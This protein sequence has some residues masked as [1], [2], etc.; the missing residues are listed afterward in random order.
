[1]SELKEALLEPLVR[2]KK[3]FAFHEDLTWLD[4]GTPA[5]YADAQ[6]ELLK[7]MPAARSLVESKMREISPGCWV[8][9]DWKSGA[10]PTLKAPVVMHGSQKEWADMA[11]IVGPRFVG[12]LP[13]PPGVDFPRNNAL[14]HWTHV[15]KLSLSSRV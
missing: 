4:I 7:C 6:L 3:L 14:V 10:S 15:E 11:N 12:I 9:R 1:M 13:P 5:S 8:P 2:E